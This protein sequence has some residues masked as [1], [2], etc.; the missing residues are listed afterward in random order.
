MKRLPLVEA[1]ATVP[2]PRKRR[3]RRHPLKAVLALSVVAILAGCKSLE[4][5]AR[6]GR[7]HGPALTH[8]LGFTRGEGP[9]R[10][11]LS[12]LFRRLDI[13]AFEAA[14]TRWV[15]DRQSD[16]W[17]ALAVDGKALKGS[18]DGEAPAVGLLAAYVPA[19]AAVIAPLRVDAK[20]NEHK[21]ALRLLG[22][23][24]PLAGKVVTGDAMFTHRD[25]AQKVVDSGGDY[26][27]TVKDNQPELK[28]QIL[29]ALYDDAD[30]PP[31]QRKRKDGQEQQARAVNKGHG[32]KEIREIRST[33]ALN[34]TLDWPAVGQVFE[35]GRVR[36]LKGKTEVEAVC[37]ITSR[38]RGKADAGRLLGLVRGHG[39]IENGAHYV[40][41]ETRGEDR[42]RVRTGSAPQVPAALRNCGAHLLEAVD[43]PSKA[44]ATRHSHVH[45]EETLPLIFT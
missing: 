24:P 34:E 35:R 7:E 17:V 20:T 21:A 12:K 26:V 28:A 19:A 9:T 14:L 45:P 15:L 43:A 32:R 39:G 37:G 3:G 41:D 33:T 23:P 31:Y 25:V 11:C 2:D 16:G 22:V 10:S 36:V 8:A 44:A 29:P 4:A 40:R 1:L 13:D 27:L 30:F 42:C 18:R 5:I 38:G 6:F